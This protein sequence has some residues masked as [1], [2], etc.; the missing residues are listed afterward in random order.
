LNIIDPRFKPAEFC[1]TVWSAT[2]EPGVTSKD[3]LKPDYWMHVSEKLRKGD[4]IEAIAEDGTWFAEYFVKASS[5]IEAHVVLIRDVELSKPVKK[6][7]VEPEF[8]VKHV[9]GGTWRALR[10]KDQAELKTGFKGKE[11]AQTW[12]DDYLKD[13]AA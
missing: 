5:K 13:K 6:L 4:R 2:P 1:R 3:L 9:G 7:D 11:A 10:T 8:M 12:L